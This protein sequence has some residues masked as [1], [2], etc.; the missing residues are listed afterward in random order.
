MNHELQKIPA[1]PNWTLREDPMFSVLMPPPAIAIH[2]E[3]KEE[4][5][6]PTV[7]YREA[8]ENLRAQ[9]TSHDIQPV[10]T[11]TQDDTSVLSSTGATQRK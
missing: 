5:P 7:I 10:A 6:N 2:V 1:P 3:E 11:A 9:A 8:A 4:D